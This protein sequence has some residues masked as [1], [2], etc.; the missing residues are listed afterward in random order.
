[1]QDLA[2]QVCIVGAWCVDMSRRNIMQGLTVQAC[3]VDV[4]ARVNVK[5]VK[6]TG[7]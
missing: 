4:I 3:I 1:M 7:T 5:S 2:V 6:V